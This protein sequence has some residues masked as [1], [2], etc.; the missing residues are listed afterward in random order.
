MSPLLT[1]YLS[2]SVSNNSIDNLVAFKLYIYQ[3]SEL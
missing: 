3:Y 1:F 2:N